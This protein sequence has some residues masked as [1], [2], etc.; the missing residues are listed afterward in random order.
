MFR[1]KLT[2]SEEEQH[3]RTLVNGEL[4]ESEIL[5]I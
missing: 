1:M 2:P 4:L 5:E 3:E